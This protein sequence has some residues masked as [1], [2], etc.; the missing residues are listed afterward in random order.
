MSEMQHIPLAEFA[1][2][3]QQHDTIYLLSHRDPDGDAFC[4]QL[5]LAEGLRQLKKQVHLLSPGPF[6]RPEINKWV[7]KFSLDVPELEQNDDILI[8]LLDCSAPERITY[9]NS[10]IE[11]HTTLILDHHQ[12]GGEIAAKAYIDADAPSTTVLVQQLLDQLNVELTYQIAYF[13]FFGFATDTGFFRFLSQNALPFWASISRWIEIGVTPNLIAEDITRQETLES[14][15]LL[16]RLL[17]RTKAYF[18][19]RVFITYE[20]ET[21]RKEL[22]L[23]E[24][25]SFSLYQALLNCVDVESVVVIRETPANGC[26]IGFRSKSDAIDVS[27]IAEKLNGGG[28][29]RAAGA[30]N[31]GS[32]DQLVEKILALYEEQIIPA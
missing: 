12:T 11:E 10:F 3:V 26:N 23:E 19:G 7:K 31:N 22:C 28:H 4:S 6:T 24:R 15:I 9:F 8:I 2:C 18:D 25:D 5:A 14:R 30:Q 27:I 13:L 20:T 16:G 1:Q 21:D 32:K 17:A 29:K